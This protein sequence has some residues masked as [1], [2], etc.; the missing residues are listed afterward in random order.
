[1]LSIG[2]KAADRPLD[3]AFLRVSFLLSVEGQN[4]LQVWGRDA[5]TT[6]RLQ[7]AHAF[8]QHA[9]PV[10][11]TDVFDHVLAENVVKTLVGKRKALG[12]IEV[13]HRIVRGHKICIQPALKNIIARSELQALHLVRREVAHD[14]LSSNGKPGYR[15]K[16]SQQ[17]ATGSHSAE[18]ELRS[19]ELCGQPCHA[20]QPEG[21][22]C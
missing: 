20:Q 15:P 5:H 10:R 14:L 1:M 19:F 6:S 21:I 11:V 17:S 12:R 9:L 13:Q 22:V 7:Q 8:T 2:H 3:I 16:V 18:D 4:R